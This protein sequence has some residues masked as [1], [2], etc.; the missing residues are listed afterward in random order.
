MHWETFKTLYTN[1]SLQ[2]AHYL[3]YTSCMYTHYLV[4]W[5]TSQIPL[6][7]SSPFPQISTTLQSLTLGNLLKNLDSLACA[8]QDL[9]QWREHQCCPSSINS[10]LDAELLISNQVWKVFPWILQIP[11]FTKSQKIYLIFWI[12]FDL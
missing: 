8:S 11:P 6:L 2:G 12:Q 9:A 3:I 10:V 1:D 4:T 7:L 5:R